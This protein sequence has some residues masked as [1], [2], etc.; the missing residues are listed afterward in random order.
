MLFNC[1]LAIEL[2]MHHVDFY[3]NTIDIPH[4]FQVDRSRL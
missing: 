4:L 2:K 3:Q 1:A